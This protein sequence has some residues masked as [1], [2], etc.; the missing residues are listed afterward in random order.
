VT[1]ERLDVAGVTRPVETP[2]AKTSSGPR[3]AFDSLGRRVRIDDGDRHAVIG[4]LVVVV[5]FVLPVAIAL[6][7]WALS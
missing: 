7:R 5:V 4:A 1:D 3:Y 2:N 6:W